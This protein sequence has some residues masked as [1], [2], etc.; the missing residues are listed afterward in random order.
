MS[1]LEKYG[2]IEYDEPETTAV[3]I[4]GPAIV[5]MT[6]PGKSPNFSQHRSIQTSYYGLFEKGLTYR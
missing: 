5:H 3:I 4:D 2:T 6:T 1:C